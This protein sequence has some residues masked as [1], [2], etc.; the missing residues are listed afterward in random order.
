V[1][2]GLLEELPDLTL[3]LGVAA[4]GAEELVEEQEEARFVVDH[5]GE[6]GDEGADYVVDALRRGQPRVEPFDP[7]LGVTADDLDQKPLLGPEVVVEEATADARLAG[8]MLEGGAGGAAARDGIPH[9][10]DDPLRL[11]AAELALFRGRLHH[12]RR[13][14]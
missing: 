1:G 14:P 8:H 9:R 3:D 5:L 10:V 4:T 11:V 12:Q 7:Q 13:A 6:A 2:A